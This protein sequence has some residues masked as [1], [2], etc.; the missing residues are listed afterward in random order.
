MNA[1]IVVGFVAGIFYGLLVDGTY[2]KIYFT[3]LA[4]YTIVFN[5]FLIDHSKTTRRKN[6]NVT[7]WGGKSNFKNKKK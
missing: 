7:S 4:F 6:I 3:V 2:F 5:F 1:L